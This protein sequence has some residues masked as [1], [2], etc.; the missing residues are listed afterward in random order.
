MNKK[1]TLEAYKEAWEVNAR[2]DAM[3]AVLTSTD[4]RASWD[5]ASFFAAGR[6]EISRVFG[7]MEQNGIGPARRRRFMDFGCGV[8]RNSR[9]LI[10]KFDAGTGVDIS[11]S[12]VSQA[13]NYAKSDARAAT[14]VVNAVPN[15]SFIADGSIDFVYSHI[16]LQHIPSELQASYV[17][18]FFR[19]LAP[20]GMA[21]FQAVTGWHA[22]NFLRGAKRFLSPYVRGIRARVGTDPIRIEMHLLREQRVRQLCA[23]SDLSLLASPYTNSTDTNHAG[24]VEFV[25]RARAIERIRSNE[26][27]SDYLSQFFFA[28]K[29]S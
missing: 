27:S 19:V 2:E 5:A 9:A 7:F 29:N 6:E 3:Y 20:G 14:Y 26:T 28:K 4:K 15:L 12:M 16:V 21:G 22:A 18:E 1:S 17:A 10:E 23:S 11:A 25:T 13:Q 24:R 8:G